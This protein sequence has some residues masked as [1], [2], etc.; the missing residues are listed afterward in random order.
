MERTYLVQR[1]LKPKEAINPFSFGGGL[2]NGGLSNDALNLIG[3][4]WS[5]DY[6]GSAEFEFGA[7]PKTLS[8]ILEYSN[9]NATNGEIKLIKPIFYLCEKN[10]KKNVEERIKQIAK[11]K[12]AYLKEPTFLKESLMGKNFYDYAGWLELN[13]NFMFFIDEEMFFNSLNF[14]GIERKIK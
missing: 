8:K 9:K 4:I 10:M 2:K 3:K 5:F 11:E 6:M 1:L 13:N 12:I 14:F 7:V